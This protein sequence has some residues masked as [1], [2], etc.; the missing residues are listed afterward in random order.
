[1]SRNAY[2]YD[3]LLSML[4]DIDSKH[5]T[6]LT[7]L[8][9]LKDYHKIMSTKF[10]DE[11]VDAVKVRYEGLYRHHVQAEKMRR[12][13]EQNISD[14]Y[15]INEWDLFVQLNNGDKFIYDSFYN[16]ITFD[17]YKSD[18]LTREQEAKEFR[19]N[20]K[21]FMDRKRLTQ[22]ELAERIGVTRLTINKYL[23]GQS[24]P[25]HWVVRDMA[26]VLGCSVEDFYYK[27]Y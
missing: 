4:F 25:S 19:K 13:L 1:M 11:S 5:H 18:E 3:R 24:N 8:F 27:R 21:K 7:D 12:Y 14:C 9:L 10:E 16:R 6:I 15:D 22:E 20:L 17:I 2:L 23:N 26:K